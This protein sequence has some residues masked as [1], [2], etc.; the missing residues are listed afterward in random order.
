ML[1]LPSCCHPEW[2]RWQLGHCQLRDTIQANKHPQE[3]VCY[4]KVSLRGCCDCRGRHLAQPPRAPAC[5][6]G[7]ARGTADT[8]VPGGTHRPPELPPSLPLGPQCFDTRMT[9]AAGRGEEQ[10]NWTGCHPQTGAVSSHL[11]RVTRVLLSHPAFIS[12]VIPPAHIPGARGLI[13]S[14]HGALLSPLPS[15]LSAG[16]GAGRLV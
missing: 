14:L 10:Q 7:S 1:S 3:I 15:C 6:Q 4:S 13:A 11:Q 8:V 12:L 9:Q 2:S 16:E 5:P